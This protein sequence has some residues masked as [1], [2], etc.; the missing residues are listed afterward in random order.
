MISR[1]PATGEPLGSVA[2]T[3]PAAIPD[4]VAAVGSVQPLWALLRVQDRARYMRRMAQAIIDQR[5]ELAQTIAAEQGRPQREVLALELL[6]AI[7]ALEWIAAQGAQALALR[8]VGVPRGMFP[9]K[10]ARVA[11]EPFG[12][13]GVIGAGSAPFVQPLGQ[14][15]GALLAGNGVVFKPALRACLAGERIAAVLG[16]AG[17]PE[18]LVRIVHGGSDGGV[19]LAQAPVDK[20]LF[21]GSPAVGRAVARACVSRGTEVT[22]ELGGKDAMLV[23][24]DAHL[25]RA[26]DCALWAGC[27]GAGQARGSVER[28]YVAQESY[29][30]FLAELVRAAGA[31]T[32]GDPAD[33][34]VGLGPLASQRR[35]AHVGELIDDA[36]A[37]GARL[38]CGG[39]LAAS[40]DGRAGDSQWVP[41]YCGPAVLAD[42]SHEMRI[43]H[44]PIDGPVVAVMAADSLDQAIALANDSNY[45]L[46]ASIWTADRYQGLRVARELR[47]GM[48]WL[49]DHLPGPAISRGPWGSFAGA[50]LGKTLGL[51]GLRACSQE[52][53][54]T[55]D[56]AGVGGMWWGPYDAVAGQA[57]NALAQWRSARPTDRRRAWR[58]GPVALARVGG[59]ALRRH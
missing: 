46:G 2:V 24:A 17:L 52:K 18:G 50:G 26:A 31:I 53:L 34:A 54:I 5:D 10:R 45:S 57:A 29:E 44:E 33:P 11:F 19:A 37:K 36:V 20:V 22:V 35:L 4:V 12:V 47:V 40:A 38:L 14:I 39:P 49:N 56:P 30:P 13:V 55:H 27:V 28:I 41:A 42:A 51:A 7:D 23:L 9:L 1:N 3:E 25:P 15:A 6:P 21:T 43:M 16:R 8:R 59:R 48:V 58:S 32:V